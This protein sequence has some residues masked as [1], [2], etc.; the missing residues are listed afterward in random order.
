MRL[1]LSLAVAVALCGCAA[2]QQKVWQKT[3]S[4]TAQ[5][6]QALK[7]CLY[8]ARKAV[9]PS[10][11]DPLAIAIAGDP[12][13]FDVERLANQCMDVRGYRLVAKPN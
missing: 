1:L 4:T 2:Q 7:E 13:Q 3:G 10:R 8:D 9:P 6:E 12:T 5:T 11:E